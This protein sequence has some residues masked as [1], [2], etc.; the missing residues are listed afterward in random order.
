[1]NELVRIVAD[2]LEGATHGVNTQLASVPRDAGD[3][4]PGSVTIYDETRD[5]RPAR[6]R[7]PDGT[8]DLPALTVSLRAVTH[9]TETIT[10]DG[11]LSADIMVQYAAKNVDAWK[12]KQAGYY[13]LRAAAW[14]LR[15]L[16]RADVGAAGRTRNS[17]TLITVDPIRF[18]P[19]FER[20]DDTLVVGTLVVPITARD[21]GI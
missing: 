8:T 12:A 15:Q 6:G 17:I 14:S 4:A 20:I 2:W 7:V 3:A 10:D 19:W 1:M 16:R 18:E 9:L 11:H 13:T 21:Y 5:N